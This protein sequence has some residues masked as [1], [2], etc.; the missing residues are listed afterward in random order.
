MNKKKRVP[1]LVLIDCIHVFLLKHADGDGKIE[2]K[3]IPTVLGRGLHIHK[4]N[5]RRILK[6]LESF[7]I[8]INSQ[9][10]FVEI[11]KK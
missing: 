1:K 11:K 7:G 3:Q 9:K 5:H 10:N 2:R 6:E 8:I 4:E